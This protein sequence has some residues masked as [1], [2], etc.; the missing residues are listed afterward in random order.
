ME[1]SVPTLGKSAVIFPGIGNAEKQKNPARVR[2]VFRVGNRWLSNSF[3]CGFDK[4]GEASGI[5][6]R[7]LREHFAVDVDV[8]FA[9]A[10]NK[11]AVADSVRTAGRVDADRRRRVVTRAPA[12]TTARAHAWRESGA[13]REHAGRRSLAA[14]RRACD[15]SSCSLLRMTSLDSSLHVISCTLLVRNY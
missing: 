6:D 5:E 7:N 14:A 15:T 9:Q 11:A 1:K 8:G 10:V 12:G 2:R 13:A 4:F 3:F